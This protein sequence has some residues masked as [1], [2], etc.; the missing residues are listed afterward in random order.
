MYARV[1]F[2]MQ[3]SKGVKNYIAFFCT[4]K[5][6]YAIELMDQACLNEFYKIK[7]SRRNLL[8]FQ[9]HLREI[10]SIS[11]QTGYMQSI[12]AKYIIAYFYLLM[13]TCSPI[14]ISNRYN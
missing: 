6:W 13:A 7:K 2:G 11:N 12:K 9:D 3:Y 1:S 14:L 8:N 4:C 5:T 10:N